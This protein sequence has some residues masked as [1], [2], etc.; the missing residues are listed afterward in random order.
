MRPRRAF[1]LYAL[2]IIGV[3]AFASGSALAQDPVSP[4]PASTPAPTGS[5]H[6]SKIVQLGCANCHSDPQIEAKGEGLY[7][8]GSEVLDSAHGDQICIACHLQIQGV[9][10]EDLAAE[11]QAA[12]G[13]CAGCHEEQNA[14]WEAGSHGSG[15][16]AGKPT[17]VTCHGAHDVAQTD[18]RDFI[19]AEAND[20]C[21]R[22]HD[23]RGK[24][25]FRY[26]YHGKETNL[27]RSDTA[28]CAD[29]HGAHEVLPAADPRSLVS[30]ANRREMCAECHEGAN[31]NFADVQI[32]V[33][34]D[35]I[36][37]DP[38]LAAATWYFIVILTVT[39]GLFG[40]H[41]VLSLK[42]EWR[43]RRVSTAIDQGNDV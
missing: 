10:H 16:P 30:D 23:E 43:K 14:S 2:V 34:A 5:S 24:S 38:K 41:M 19:I 31:A 9:L 27:G 1:P 39:F 29:C 7:V 36:P 12:R 3:M 4:A 13:S 28:V 20:R 8:P 32:H 6:G 35:P 40:W 17:C 26:N 11:L 37:S 22:C 25:F 21:S 42:H 33:L 15:D 18:S